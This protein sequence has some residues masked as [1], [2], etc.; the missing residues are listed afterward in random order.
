MLMQCSRK[1]L[2]TTA[3]SADSAHPGRLTRPGWQRWRWPCPASAAEGQ[4]GYGIASDDPLLKLEPTSRI[5]IPPPR[6]FP[7]ILFPNTTCL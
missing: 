5:V 4:A 6:R 7:D 1:V 3:Y 2:R